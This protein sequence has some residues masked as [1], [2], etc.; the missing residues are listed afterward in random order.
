MNAEVPALAHHFVAFLDLL[1]FSAMVAGEAEHAGDDRSSFLK[2]RDAHQQTRSRF[3]KMPGYTLFQFSDSIVLARQFDKHALPEFLGVVADYQR[4]LLERELL[5]R[6][7]I[8]YGK[9]FVDGSFL[10]S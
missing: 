4:S 1:G 8:A 6:G 2:L 7:G 9:H 3:E 5:C 10:F